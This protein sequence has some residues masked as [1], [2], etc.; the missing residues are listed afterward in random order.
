LKK[1]A[2]PT[3]F[4]SFPKYLQ[5]NQAAPRRV[6][7]RT[8]LEND[9]D[10]LPSKTRKLDPNL[11]PISIVENDHTYCIPPSQKLKV[12]LDQERML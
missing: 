8:N 1:D 11:S 4:D 5:T 6:L 9:P 10:V 2:V 12:L 3:I 7:K